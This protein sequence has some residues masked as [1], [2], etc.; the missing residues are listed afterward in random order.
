M[1]DARAR[2]GVAPDEEHPPPKRR[3]A[4]HGEGRPHGLEAASEEGSDAAEAVLLGPVGRQ[5]ERGGEVLSD[6]GQI[7]IGERA[8]RIRSPADGGNFGV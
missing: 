8:D 4:L 1:L 6:G 5:P 7:G 3:R 2:Q